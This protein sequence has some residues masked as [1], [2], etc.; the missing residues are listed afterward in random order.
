MVD[1][2][3]HLGREDWQAVCEKKPPA[4]ARQAKQSRSMTDPL[5]HRAMD[6][7]GR[8]GYLCLRRERLK[9]AQQ[10]L[11]HITAASLFQKRQPIP[12]ER[13]DLLPPSQPSA[14]LLTNCQGHCIGRNHFSVEECNRD[15][16]CRH[17]A[18][19]WSS[20]HQGCDLLASS[21]WQTRARI[22]IDVLFESKR[23]VFFSLQDYIRNNKDFS[24]R[25]S[26]NEVKNPEI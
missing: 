6:I 26:V 23:V 7:R 8:I 24:L 17:L 18:S 19:R 3:Q 16:R 4:G 1:R 25:D 2:G 14:L 10:L 11:S 20:R 22:L 21:R 15:C 12:I 5:V 9:S 13:T